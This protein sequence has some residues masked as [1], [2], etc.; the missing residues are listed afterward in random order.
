MATTPEHGWPTPDNTDRVADGASAI[1]ALGDAIDSALPF[2]YTYAGTVG[3]LAASAEASTTVTFP[4]GYFA[5][6]PRV[7]GTAI[8]GGTA[9]VDITS[10]TTSSCSVKVKNIGSAS[11][12]GA[13]HI[14]AII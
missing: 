10:I 1:R 7:V 12:G 5:A 4:V 9:N 8:T 13:F 6:A 11:I 3:T 2:I 14:I